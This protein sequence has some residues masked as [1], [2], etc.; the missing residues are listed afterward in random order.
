MAISD[1]LCAL[2]YLLIG[3]SQVLLSP[4]FSRMYLL[5]LLSSSDVFFFNFL[6]YR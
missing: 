5:V 1:I 6:F 4:S 3:F 2:G